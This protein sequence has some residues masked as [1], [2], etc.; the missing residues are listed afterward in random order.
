[1]PICVFG[2]DALFERRLIKVIDGV[3]A[4]APTGEVGVD[5][6]LCAIEAK[7]APGF[8]VERSAYFNWHASQPIVGRFDSA[9]SERDA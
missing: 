1:M 3:I 6:Y 2:C 7:A 4:T 9:T 5:E 8:N